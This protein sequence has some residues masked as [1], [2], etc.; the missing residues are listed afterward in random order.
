MFSNKLFAAFA[1]VAAAVT[2]ATAAPADVS[3]PAILAP[4]AGDVW[5]VGSNQTI[6]WDTSA[7][8]AN[9]RNQTGLV[10]L[11]FLEDGSDDE[12][13]DTQNPLA[14]NFPIVAGSINISVPVVTPRDD[15]IIVLF[16]DSGNFSPKFT[17]AA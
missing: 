3:R 14:V 16:G 4:K 17:I 5:T 2:A 1:V 13:L 9:S 12:H 11:G 8:P 10:L 6:A 15:Y 7:I